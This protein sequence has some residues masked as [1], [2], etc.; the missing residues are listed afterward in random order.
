[1]TLEKTNHANAKKRIPKA[2]YA[3]ILKSLFSIML[4]AFFTTPLFAQNNKDTSS[5]KPSS[6][7]DNTFSQMLDY[8]RPGKYHKLLESLEG[9]WTYI[10][11]HPNSDGKVEHP[12]YGTFVWR[13]FANGRFFIGDVTSSKIQMPIQDGK[14][15]E[16]NYKAIYT[17]GYNNIKQKFQKTVITN[18]LGSDIALSDGDYN[19]KTN[20][21]SFDGVDE[22]IPGMKS[23]VRE[24][25]EFVDKNHYTLETYEE[26]NGNYVKVNEVRCT[27]VKG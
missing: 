14:S 12:Y 8:S 11:G 2:N 24:V 4:A 3:I 16:T 15:K 6:N 18:M 7:E 17:I 25:L 27:K 10:G 20:T 22:L 9:N 26:E 13:S 21:I 19:E 23:K 5:S 1:M